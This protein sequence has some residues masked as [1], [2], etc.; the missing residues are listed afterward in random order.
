MK[1]PFDIKYRQQIEAGEY[2]LETRDGNQARIVCWDKKSDDGHNVIALVTGSVEEDCY[3]YLNNG[4]LISFSVESGY[5]LFI[6]MP[7]PKMTE[8]EGGMLRYLQDGVNCKDDSEIITETKKH[9]EHLLRLARKQINE[10][11][12]AKAEKEGYCIEDAVAF[13][14]GFKT[15]KELFSKVKKQDDIELKRLDTSRLPTVDEWKWLINDCVWEWDSE[16]CGRIVTAKNGNSIFLPAAG[17]RSGASISFANSIGYYWS[18][19]PADI[20]PSCAYG[21]CFGS[22]TIYLH[23]YQRFCEFSA[24]YVSDVPQ[25]GY[26]DMGNGLFWAENNKKGH[27]TYNELNK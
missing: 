10:E 4:R 8:F 14:E 1:I 5:D 26:I 6:D 15:A 3:I 17:Y 16:R 12:E 19:S 9:S 2:K 22:S 25:D 21:L 7:D 11:V 24:R 20:D 27:Y 18:S 13:D 23:D